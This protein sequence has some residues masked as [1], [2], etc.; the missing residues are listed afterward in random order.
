MTA[1]SS[2]N[3]NRKRDRDTMRDSDKRLLL[4]ELLSATCLH[5]CSVR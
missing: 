5:V 4:L 3:T 2:T 1:L